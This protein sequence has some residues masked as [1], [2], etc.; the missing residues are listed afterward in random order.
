MN[1]WGA[2]AH[3]STPGVHFST[4]PAC[5]QRIVKDVLKLLDIYILRY[6]NEICMDAKYSSIKKL[7]SIA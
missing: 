4:T 6:D 2:Q 7:A 3:P 5:K 1:S